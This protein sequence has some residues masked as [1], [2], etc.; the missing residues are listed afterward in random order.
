MRRKKAAKGEGGGYTSYNAM[1]KIQRNWDCEEASK[2]LP[3]LYSKE[4]L[5]RAFLARLSKRLCCSK[6]RSISVSWA[7]ASVI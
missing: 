2:D 7:R 3:E 6:L 1:F 5:G 4:K